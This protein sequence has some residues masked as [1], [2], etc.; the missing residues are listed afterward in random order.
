M[1]KSSICLG[2]AVVSGLLLFFSLI[3]RYFSRYS[4]DQHAIPILNGCIVGGVIGFVFFT[5]CHVGYLSDEI[6]DA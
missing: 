3:V 5:V 4:E 1:E 2:L 6:G